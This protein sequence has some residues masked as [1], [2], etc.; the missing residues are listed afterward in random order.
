MLAYS[1]FLSENRKGND[2]MSKNLTAYQKLLQYVSYVRH[3]AGEDGYA[4]L[5]EIEF[6]DYCWNYKN[7]PI[8]FEMRPIA[9]AG[10]RYLYYINWFKKRVDIGIYSDAQG[11]IY[12]QVGRFDEN[13]FPISVKE[14]TL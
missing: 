6:I 14:Y 7:E 12:V 2:V 1:L 9:Y 13:D 5:K 10:M 3:Y 4:H 8:P 11:N